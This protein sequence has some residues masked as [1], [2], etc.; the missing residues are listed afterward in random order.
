MKDNN[1]QNELRQKLK[2]ICSKVSLLTTHY[3]EL[4]QKVSCC[5]ST[6]LE[7]A[8]GYRPLTHRFNAG[9]RLF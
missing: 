4:Q 5:G 8:M 2:T 3:I 9:Y 6:V 1:M 7:M